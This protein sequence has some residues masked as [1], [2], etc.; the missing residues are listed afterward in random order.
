MGVGIAEG[1]GRAINAARMA[2]SSNLLEDGRIGGARG[3]LI[4]ITGGASLTMY[5]INEAAT[6]IQEEA[7]EDANIIFGAVIDE[8]MEDRV[9]ITVIATGFGEKDEKVLRPF[10]PEPTQKRKE[11]HDEPRRKDAGLDSRMFDLSKDEAEILEDLD[12]TSLNIRLKRSQPVLNKTLSSEAKGSPWLAKVSRP[13]PVANSG[14]A[15]SS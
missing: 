7:H 2:V 8:A 10:S 6:L 4:N 15:T 5:E 13:T 3:I 11:P 1:D 12:M 9:R 14:V